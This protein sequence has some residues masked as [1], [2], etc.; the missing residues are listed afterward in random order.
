MC[1]CQAFAHFGLGVSPVVI[2]WVS[3]EFLFHAKPMELLLSRSHRSA[4]EALARSAWPLRSLVSFFT[5]TPQ[6]AQKKLPVY[7]YLKW[8]VKLN[9]C[10]RNFK[11]IMNFKNYEFWKQFMILNYIHGFQKYS[12]IWIRVLVFTC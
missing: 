11:N 9:D 12:Q 2:V 5:L 6:L 1:G 4:H 8:L 3:W 7:F 10:L